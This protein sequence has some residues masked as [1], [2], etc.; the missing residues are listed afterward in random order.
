MTS[1]GAI[2]GP[3]TLRLLRVAVS[4]TATA[5]RAKV[6]SAR[7]PLGQVQHIPIRAGNSGRQPLHPAALLKQ[8]K[9]GARWFSSA[10]AKQINSVVRRYFT[11]GPTGP[12]LDRSKLPSSNTSRRVAQF[13]GQAPF[14]SALRPNLTGGA[15]PRT[16]G[17]Y[18]IGGG[19][20]Y[21][22]HTPAAPAQVVQNV[23]QAMRAFFLSGQK[24]RYDGVGPRGERQYRAVSGVEDEAMKRLAA[25]SRS[26]PGAFVDFKLSPTV[27]ALSPLAA[28]ITGATGTHGFK[29][30]TMA[31]PTS[32]NTDGF[33]DVLSADFGRALKDL[34]A[35]YADLRRLS[36]LGDLPIAME[37][38]NVLRVRFPGVDE[39]TVNRLCDDI[40]IDRG[41][42]GED[43]DFN[44]AAGVPMALQ[45]P[46]APDAE[47]TLTS[48]GGSA[49]SVTGHEFDDTSSLDDDDASFLRD[50]FVEVAE[51]PWLSDPEGYE[52]MS[53]P[54]SSGERCST[55]FEGLEGIY[56]FIEEC[57]RGEGRLG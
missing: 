48:P 45:F 16:A 19:A 24:L 39:E 4:R 42:V 20:R 34:T 53:P 21:F 29:A 14:A 13:S 47:K 10:T 2:W 49:R 55:D 1:V 3:A 25:I 6:A 35:V 23:S 36:V 15:M 51:N 44:A 7:G 8:Q 41:V 18:S 26:A 17:G 31:S 46:F 28:A 32:L 12:R 43:P 50:A 11:Y 37:G 40:G 22:S 57:D 5:V 56:R 38:S 33:L 27:T 54:L 9:R 30:E 52:S